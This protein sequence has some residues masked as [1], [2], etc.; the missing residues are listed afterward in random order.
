MTLQGKEF[1][2]I[3]YYLNNE[4]EDEAMRENPP[5]T[6]LLDKLTRSI[7]ATDPRVTRFPADFD[8]PPEEMPVEM[9]V[10][11]HRGTVASVRCCD[12]I[13]WPLV[14]AQLCSEACALQT[15]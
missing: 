14:L 8:N 7:L 4:Y 15:L 6:P 12:C 5:E 2:R 10:S 13:V 11:T 9:M 3:G 1:I